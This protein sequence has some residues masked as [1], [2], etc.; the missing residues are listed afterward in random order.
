MVA[1]VF[2][3]NA[4]SVVIMFSFTPW[5]TNMGIRNAYIL[6]SVLAIVVL[7][8]PILLLKWGK[9][10][11]RKTAPRYRKFAQLQVSHRQV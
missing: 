11:R 2:L 9:A 1:V 7:N 10:L 5:I 6:I 3:R 4:L 8:V